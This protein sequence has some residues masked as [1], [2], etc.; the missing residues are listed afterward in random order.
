[1]LLLDRSEGIDRL[2]GALGAEPPDPASD[3][4]L[5]LIGSPPRALW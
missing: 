3:R 5:N 2:M 4:D 1:M